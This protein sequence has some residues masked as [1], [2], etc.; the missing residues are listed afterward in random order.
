MNSLRTSRELGGGSVDR[1]CPSQSQAVRRARVLR[2]PALSP[3]LNAPE[4]AI[5]LIDASEPVSE[6]D[7]R[8]RRWRSTPGRAV[9]LAF[10][11]WDLVDEDR[12][13]YLDREIDRDLAMVA[14][15]P[16]VNVSALTGR[17]YG[18]AHGRVGRCPR[19]MGNTSVHGQVEQVSPTSR[20]P[21]PTR[22]AAG[23]S[24]GSCSA[25]RWVSARHPSRCSRRG[26]LRPGID[27]SSSADCGRSSVSPA[28]RSA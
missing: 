5:V 11:K 14:W 22:C 1:R 6:Q 16:R 13:R 27:A 21:T 18:Q 25:R 3:L 9:V 17:R 19:R 26:S 20:L 12:R 7:V 4:V 24:R 23:S 2:D 15:A 10:N 28:V 8:I